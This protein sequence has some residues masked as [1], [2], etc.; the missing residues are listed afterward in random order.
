MKNAISITTRDGDHD[1]YVHAM[2]L[3]K[4]ETAAIAAMKG[5]L[6]NPEPV[7]PA[8]MEGSCRQRNF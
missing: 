2:G 1:H 8:I 4:R 3:T 7:D 5:H 6:A